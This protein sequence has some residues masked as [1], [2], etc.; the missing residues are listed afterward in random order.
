MIE[1]DKCTFFVT[2]WVVKYEM[3]TEK[4]AKNEDHG[5]GKVIV[6]GNIKKIE[7]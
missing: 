4:H 5:R 1:H 7:R 2:S 3:E 6:I